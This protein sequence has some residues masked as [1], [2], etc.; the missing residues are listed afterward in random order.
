[1]YR[2]KNEVTMRELSLLACCSECNPA[3][4]D[5]LIRKWFKINLF[6]ITF[7]SLYLVESIRQGEG[8]YYAHISG[9]K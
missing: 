9:R 6:E 5:G 2:R 4:G 3:E 1:M 7:S 8:T